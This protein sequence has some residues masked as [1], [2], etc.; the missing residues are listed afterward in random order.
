M[1]STKQRFESLNADV[2][3]GFGK[4]TGDDVEI[5]SSVS[6]AGNAGGFRADDPDIMRGQVPLLGPEQL[7]AAIAGHLSHGSP[8]IGWARELGDLHAAMIPVH[9][10]LSQHPG[11]FDAAGSHADIVRIGGE[12]DSWAVHHVP[13]TPNVRKHTHSLG[14]VISHVAKVYADAWWTVLHTTDRELRHEAWFHLAEVREGY[15]ALVTE[16]RARRVQLP[17][18]WCANRR[19]PLT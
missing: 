9:L 11:D 8:L 3:V 19:N 5:L 12:I 10:N 7:L 13:R 16:I 18:G 1:K 14:E 6:D 2:G 4:R 15:A 17:L